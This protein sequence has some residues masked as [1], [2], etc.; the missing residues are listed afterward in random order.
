MDQKTYT[1]GST[2]LVASRFNIHCKVNRLP[3]LITMSPATQCVLIYT[4][5]NLCVNIHT[6][7]QTSFYISMHLRSEPF[8]GASP[9]RL[10][11][12]VSYRLSGLFS[13]LPRFARTGPVWKEI[14]TWS[15][16]LWR[17]V[18]TLPHPTDTSLST[19][20]AAATD[21]P[22]TTWFCFHAFK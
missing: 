10:Q 17:W 21:L 11:N 16:A 18:I 22:H 20:E 3:G 19:L 5:S 7:R 13:S 2:L 14:R 12:G 15:C 4:C 6:Y 8:G 1:C 9:A